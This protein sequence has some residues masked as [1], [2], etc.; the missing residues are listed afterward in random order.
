MKIASQFQQSPRTLLWLVA[1]GFFMQTLDSTI[2]NTALP[3]IAKDLNESPLHMQWVLVSYMLTNAMIIPASGWL[4]DRFG[5][6]KIFSIAIVLFIIGS[7]ICAFSPNLSVLVG[8][9]VVQ[10]CGAAMLMPVGRL[11]VLR[12]FPKDRFLKAM[13]FVT[14]PGLIGQVIGPTL[15]GWLAEMLSWHWVFLINLP[16]GIAG[17]VATW[18]A[19][20]DKRAPAVDPFDITG[21]LYLAVAMVAISLS[22]DGFSSLGLERALVVLLLVLGLAACAI[23][24]LHAQR[25]AHPLFNRSLFKVNSFK[26]G[27]LGNIFARIG[28]GS[29]PFML[30]LFMQ[31]QLD[32][33]PAQAG[34][35]MLPVAFAAIFAKRMATSLIGNFGYRWVLTGNTLLLGAMIASFALMSRE[36]PLIL[37]LLLLA[38]FGAANSLQFTAMNTVTLKDLDGTTASSGNTMLSMTQ[39]LSM[40]L[41]VSIASTILQAFND[42][43]THSLVK[44]ASL[45]AFHLSFVLIGVMSCIAS[46]I[47]WHLP[48]DRRPKAHVESLG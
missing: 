23:Y 28:T 45:T 24:W 25:A 20:P 4:A 48:A 19:M 12:T 14:I 17:V 22:L 30:P 32:Y 26:V 9:R 3:S 29:M 21:Y 35:M 16:I 33:S 8:G 46:L 7:A 10:G 27:I 40:S 34:M 37:S 44:D 31:T 5:T 38:C 36:Q 41:G 11:A 2:V 1:I 13:S 43:L 18:H 42:M 15:G 47:F 6:R 39:M